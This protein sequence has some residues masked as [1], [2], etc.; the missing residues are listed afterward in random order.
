MYIGFI[1]VFGRKTRQCPCLSS[2][3]AKEQRSLNDNSAWDNPKIPVLMLLSC[4]LLKVVL[5]ISSAMP[6]VAQ[7]GSQIRC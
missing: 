6:V 1:C 7:S 5:K 4:L 3:M 2:D